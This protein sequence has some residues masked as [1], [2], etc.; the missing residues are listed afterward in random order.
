MG[1][2]PGWGGGARLVRLVGRQRALQMLGTAEKLNL[3]EAIQC[4]LVDREIP[5]EQ[6]GHTLHFIL[7][8]AW[9]VHITCNF[10][11]TIVISQPL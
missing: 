2:S 5:M 6:V 1:V 9:D 4:G 8:W 10:Y 11:D 7:L 3:N